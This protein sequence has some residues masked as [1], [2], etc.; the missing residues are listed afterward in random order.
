MERN[1]W[2]EGKINVKVLGIVKEKLT[3]VDL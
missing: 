2:M 3:T 1:G